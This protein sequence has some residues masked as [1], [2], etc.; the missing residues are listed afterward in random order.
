M[1]EIFVFLCLAFS[2]YAVEIHQVRDGGVASCSNQEDYI[3]LRKRN[4]FQL[5]NPEVRDMGN[6]IGITVEM[7]F[8]K[9]K[10]F[11]NRFFFVHDRSPHINKFQDINSSGLVTIYTAV[12]NRVL[13]ATNDQYREVGRSEIFRK[14]QGVELIIDKSELSIN[15]SSHEGEYYI[16]IDM[17]M[18][19][20]FFSRSNSLNWERTNSSSYRLFFDLDVMK[21]SF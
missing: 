14:A 15:N 16:D 11:E 21:A 4:A 17:I 18:D 2:S 9:C 1:K 6:S 20:K 3:R 8:Y 7:A 5:K 19:R 10:K 13:R 12:K